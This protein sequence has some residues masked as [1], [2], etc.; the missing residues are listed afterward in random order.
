MLADMAERATVFPVVTFTDGPIELWGARDPGA[1]A[2]DYTKHLR[3]YLQ[4]LK[5]LERS[6][7]V[8]A[9]YVDN[10]SANLVVRLLEIM[11]AEDR[12]LANMRR[13]HPLH[14]A[15]DFTLF[16]RILQPG[17]RSAVFATQT[18][19]ARYYED[20]L[21]LH[22]FYMNVGR[23]DH[24]WL[25]RIE[26]PAWVVMDPEKLAALQAVIMNQCQAMG[27][28]PYPYLLHRAHETAVVSLE[29]REQVTQMITL[30]LRRH[31]IEPGEQSQKQQHKNLPG[32]TGY[33]K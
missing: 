2:T 32:R 27:S 3:D 25:A 28:R 26:I 4:A 5:R 6:G 15:T 19:S 29:E 11:V 33:T 18:Q 13:Y 12:D 21:A 30:E 17:Q 22:F 20:G 14:G 10:P 8:T 23:Q 9:G 1:E 7:A 16:R 31:G 24:S